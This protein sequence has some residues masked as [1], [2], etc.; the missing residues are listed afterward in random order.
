M[1]PF[2]LASFLQHCRIELL[3]IGDDSDARPTSPTSSRYG[4]DAPRQAIKI[5]Y[6]GPD[7][8]FQEMYCAQNVFILLNFA[9]VFLPPDL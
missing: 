1:R 8:I 3:Q 9:T 6:Q 4:G 5:Y 7:N 2:F